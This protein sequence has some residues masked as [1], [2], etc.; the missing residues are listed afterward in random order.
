MVG[1]QQA[2]ALSEPVSWKQLETKQVGKCG[3]SHL[4]LQR[5]LSPE[6]GRGI[7][8]KPR[9]LQAAL[10][11]IQVLFA[12]QHGAFEE[13]GV[14]RRDGGHSVHSEVPRPVFPVSPFL[15]QHWR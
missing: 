10:H 6:T 11:N 2:L 9:V 7:Q 15:L 14:E 8:E 5:K 4:Q 3:Q 13:Q 12:A 1:L